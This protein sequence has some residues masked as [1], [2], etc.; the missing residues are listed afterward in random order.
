MAN[1]FETKIIRNF[2]DDIVGKLNEAA[3]IARTASALG[4]QG[5][6]VRTFLDI[7]A[8][9]HDASTLLNS[10]LSVRRRDKDANVD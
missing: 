8:L 2:A 4:T 7:E 10:T 6:L 9:I 1:E 3:N 5:L